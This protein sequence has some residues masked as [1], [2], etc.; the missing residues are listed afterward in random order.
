MARPA[1]TG[2][3]HARPPLAERYARGEIGAEEYDERLAELR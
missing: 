2:L 3:D 1:E